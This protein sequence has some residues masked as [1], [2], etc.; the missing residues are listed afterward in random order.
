M[1][2]IISDDAWQGEIKIMILFIN[3]KSLGKALLI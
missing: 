2:G 3:N 1:D